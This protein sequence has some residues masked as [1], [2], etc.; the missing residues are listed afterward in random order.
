MTV[1]DSWM[2]KEVQTSNAILDQITDRQEIHT[3]HLF[4]CT[5]KRTDPYAFYS[6]ERFQEV[7]EQE[8][9]RNREVYGIHG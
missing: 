1:P 9:V 7:V 4:H 6:S 2:E 8:R 3:G 5:S